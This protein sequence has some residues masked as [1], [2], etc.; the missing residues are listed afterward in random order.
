MNGDKH[1]LK[2]D[3]AKQYLRDRKIYVTEFPFKPTTAA[4]T[5]VAKTIAR[6]KMQSGA[7]ILHGVRH[8][9]VK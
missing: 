2:L 6:Y 4:G 1:T 8:V 7:R 9:E 5:D 3:A